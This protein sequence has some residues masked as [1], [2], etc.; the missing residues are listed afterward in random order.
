[1]TRANPQTLVTW[2]KIQM[3]W[4]IRSLGIEWKSV[5]IMWENLFWRISL[6]LFPQ[7]VVHV[8]NAFMYEEGVKWSMSSGVTKFISFFADAL[9]L[10]CILFFWF[11]DLSQNRLKGTKANASS[12]QFAENFCKTLFL[13]I[14]KKVARVITYIQ[15]IHKGLS[16][17]F[18][19]RK[20]Q[21][22]FQGFP[23]SFSSKEQKK[24]NN[25]PSPP[26]NK[27]PRSPDLANSEAW[28]WEYKKLGE[29]VN[30]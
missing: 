18:L 11:L 12:I 25:T 27:W 3:G 5:G 7:G 20:M 1:M 10:L 2:Q 13:L 6:F 23:S 8:T 28:F 30:Q 26:N 21:E 4:M 14:D 15:I 22:K 17:L 24:A 29:R 9:G 16:K 19:T